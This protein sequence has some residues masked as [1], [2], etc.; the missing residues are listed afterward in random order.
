MNRILC[1]A[2]VKGTVK[3]FQLRTTGRFVDCIGTKFL[4]SSHHPRACS[5]MAA[6]NNDEESTANDVVLAW[7]ISQKQQG[8]NHIHIHLLPASEV[9]AT[10]QPNAGSSQV[11]NNNNNNPSTVLSPVSSTKHESVPDSVLQ[12]ERQLRKAQ[13]AKKA[14]APVQPEDLKV[15]YY[16]EY[17]VV[18]NKPPGV[19]TVPG[20]NSR[21]CLLELVYDKFG[22][23]LSTYSS[24]DTMEDAATKMVVHRLDM[25]TSGLVIFGRSPE[26]TKQ[27][28]GQFRDRK[29]QK[30]YE[31]IVQGHVPDF[32][33]PE[34][35]LD[36][37]NDATTLHLDLPLQRDH[38]HPPFMRVSTPA[39]EQEAAIVLRGLHQRGWT[40]LTRKR[41]KASQTRGRI[42]ERSFLPANET[43]RLPFT[44]LRLEPLTGRTHQ[45]RVHCAAVG[46]PI[47]SSDKP[48]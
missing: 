12:F 38:V 47:V 24:N 7:D 8:W 46:Y 6:D 5:S 2:V 42:L 37:K 43:S 17:I 25:D 45:L 13:H 20:I 30:E 9:V 35:G 27:L 14:G 16:D 18:V 1:R 34:E 32:F 19:L 44:R 22:P 31:C 40:K 3:Q 4:L 33:S 48:T 23:E 29:V 26:V 10:E 15:I 39:S 21:S 28:H 11:V 41:P 36:D